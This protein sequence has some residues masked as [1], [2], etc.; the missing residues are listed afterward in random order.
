MNGRPARVAVAL[1]AAGS[2]LTATTTTASAT[3][4]SSGT[5]LTVDAADALAP[6]SPLLTG[7]N[8]NE[9]FDDSLGLWDPVRRQGVP[10]A[11]AK[12]ARAG[13]GLIRYPG[14]TQANLFDWKRAIGPQAERG[15][16][17]D[18]GNGAPRDSRYGPDEHMTYTHEAGAQASM[19]V[20]FAN[21]TPADA[22]DWV[23]YLNAPLGTN[24]RGGRAWA[25]VRAANGHPAPYR[26]RYWEIGNE[27]DRTAERYWLSPDSATAMRQYAFGGTQ[28]QTGQPVGTTCDHRE[29]A[30]HSD[31]SAGQRFQVYYPP[32]VPHSQAVYVDGTAWSAVDDLTRYGPADEVYTF[33]PATGWIAFGDGTHGRVPPSGARITADYDSGP[34]AGFVDFAREMKRADPRIDVLA[35]WAPI[36]ADTGLGGTSF[37]EL[38]AEQG[39]ARDYDGITIHPYTNFRRDFGSTLTSAQQGHDWHML[40]EQH[41]TTL[42]TDLVAQVHRYAPRGTYVAPSEF[43]ALFFG[44]HDTATYEHWDTAMSHA[45]YMASQWT[46]FA[47]LGVPWAEGNTLVAETPSGL[48]AVLGGAPGFAYTS[49]AVVREQLRPLVSGGGNVVAHRLLGNPSVTTEPTALGSSYPALAATVTRD[50]D[51]RL[52][53]LVVNRSAIDPVPVRVQLA[54]FRHAPSATVSTVAGTDFTSYNDVDHP[55]GVRIETTSADVGAG[56]FDHT[57]AAHSVT[58][59][60][61]TPAN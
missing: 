5:V 16:Q 9:W 50:R 58:L 49:E 3:A 31:G 34:H 60:R 48:R 8:D 2:A 54:H 41:A 30:S 53:L 42:V 44:P 33:D 39:H 51:G 12:T 59:L 28:R 61:L 55:D 21:E 27:L 15:C 40:G 43:G 46:R 57:F 35:T 4:T 29:T 6:V 1:L 37:P 26:V 52:D 7:V 25:K 22:A 38:M 23:E 14:G 20:A 18:G 56:S 32:V 13:V 47:D 19:M 45:L 10:D 36:T 17:V 24:P 11:V